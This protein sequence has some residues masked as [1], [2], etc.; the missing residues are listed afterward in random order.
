MQGG[1]SQAENTASASIGMRI[2]LTALAPFALG[3]FLSYLFRAVNA[4]VAP[5]LV[6]DLSL[7][8]GKLGFLTAAYL[9]AF[10]LFQLP[11][12]ILLDRYGPRRVQG[13]LLAIAALGALLF[14]FGRDVVTLTFARGLIGLGFAGG[15]MASFKAVVIWV[16]EQRRAFAS[17]AVM[18]GGAL[19]LMVS[20]APMEWLVDQHG[21]RAVFAGLAALTALTAALILI[22]VPRPDATGKALPLTEQM[23]SLWTI[24]S[25]PAFVRLAPM[26]GLSAGTHIAIQTLWAGPWWRDMGGLDRAGVARSL[27]MMA[28][29][30]F[31]GI[32]GSGAAADR[33]MRRGISALD[34]MLVFMI[35]FLL[36]QGLIILD[37]LRLP[38]WIMFGMLGQVAIL[39]FPWLSGYFGAALSGRATSAMNLMIF[40]AAFVAQWAMG[41]IIDLYPRT[42][43]G[44]FPPEAYRAAFGTFLALQVA[45]LLFYLP[46][47]SR[48][49]AGKR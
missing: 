48:L 30:F 12:G 22:V 14:S 9:L 40:V 39:A 29:A 41:A 26:L 20:T 11:L 43:T 10:S 6:R 16:P 18:S 49:I 2:V 36:A 1:T 23:R 17:A 8:A 28:A 21:W 32:L 15:L 35:V 45:G 37:V 7:D 13:G 33:M 3:Y 4:V 19:G 24:M 31:V 27:F 38:V 46:V 34:V 47:R 42:A 44:G 5:D 25:D